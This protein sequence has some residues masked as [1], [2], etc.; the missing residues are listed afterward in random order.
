MEG[1]S[2]EGWCVN[3]AKTKFS[4]LRWRRLFELSAITLPFGKYK[5]SA[6]GRIPLR[7]LDQTVSSMPES[8]LIR[9]VRE[10]VDLCGDEWLASAFTSG[11]SVS[12]VFGDVSVY[13]FVENE[14]ERMRKFGE[15]ADRKL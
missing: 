9:R 1:L 13:E 4:S 5:N 8:W 11:A 15:W 3:L 14:I 12:P 7:Y 6:L 2:Y 10:L